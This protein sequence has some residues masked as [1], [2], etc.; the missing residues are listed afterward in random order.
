MSVDLRQLYLFCQESLV[1]GM[2]KCDNLQVRF[3]HA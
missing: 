3:G 1:Q 2:L